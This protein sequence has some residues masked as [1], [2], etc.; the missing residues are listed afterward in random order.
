MPQIEIEGRELNVGLSADAMPMMQ[1][2][3]PLGRAGTP[4]EAAGAIYLF[5]LP[6]SDFISGEVVVASGGARL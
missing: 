1:S 6:E 5:C 4:E 2:M 3:I